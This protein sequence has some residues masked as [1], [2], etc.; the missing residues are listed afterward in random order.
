MSTQSFYDV[1]PVD[2]TPLKCYQ[3]YNSIK[4][5]FSVARYDYFKYHLN[6]NKFTQKALDEHTNANI[7]YKISD[8][9]LYQDRFIPLLV[10][11]LFHNPATWIG[12]IV[13]SSGVARGMEY[14]KY[15]NALMPTF[16]NDLQKAIFKNKMRKPEALF[17]LDSKVNFLNLLMKKEISPVT[18]A[19]LCKTIYPKYSSNSMMSF[20]YEDKV[21]SLNK[22]AAF[23]PSVD[24]VIVMEV[25]NRSIYDF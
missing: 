11:N 6:E 10:A 12:E 5:H 2:L 22:L 20:V 3:L 4:L 18:A 14:R 21:K 8:K 16:E 15:L 13:D 19:I 17:T 7:F 1:R 23:I 25:V 24:E 9:F